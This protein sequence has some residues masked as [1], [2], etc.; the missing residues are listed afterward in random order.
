MNFLVSN[1]DGVFSAGIKALIEAIGKF[2]SVYVVAPNSEKSACGHGITVHTPIRVEKFSYTEGIPA[3][4]VEGTPADCVKLGLTTLIKEDIDWVVSGINNG[5]NLGT[6]VFYS[7][8]VAAAA[9]GVLLGV[10]ALAFSLCSF[11]SRD[12]SVAKTIVE[13]LC[14]KIF[15]KKWA[16]DTLL[17]I[18]IPNARLSDIAGI[19]VTGL[20]IR[21]YINNYEHR[22]D[23]RGKEYYWLTGQLVPPP[24]EKDLDINAIRKKY[25]SITPLQTNLTCFEKISELKTL[26][27]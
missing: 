21:E 23:P 20:G 7:G 18:N 4:S 19:K 11:S 8:T 9:E 25:V 15:E 27:L 26:D 13:N 1:D 5:P 16:S 2:G 14:G 3:W 10:P 24:I 22:L 12:F 17:N 6:D